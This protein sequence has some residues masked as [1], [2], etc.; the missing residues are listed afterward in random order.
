MTKRQT[1]Q[2]LDAES[3]ERLGH[4]DPDAAIDQKL[5][6]A[7]N[8]VVSQ[9]SGYEK[10]LK[11]RAEV[12]HLARAVGWSKYRIAKRLG[13]TRRAVDEALERPTPRSP[14]EFLDLEVQ[15]NGGHEN[16]SDRRLRV[17]LPRDGS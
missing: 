1:G 8:F 11:R 5:V 7:Q 3:I 4:G 2:H 17:L 9:R 15:R 16:A 10:S 14:R 12:I 6:S 13:I